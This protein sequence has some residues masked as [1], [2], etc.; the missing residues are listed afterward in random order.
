MVL[1]RLDHVKFET[2]AH[3]NVSLPDNIDIFPTSS[4]Q[5]LAILQS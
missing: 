5:G 1:K 4:K 3:F 2:L